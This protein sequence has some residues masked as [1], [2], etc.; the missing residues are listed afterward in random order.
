M[1]IIGF[2]A[3]QNVEFDRAV[4]R[5]VDVKA[6][7]A[8]ARQ[9]NYDLTTAV[10]VLTTGDYDALP[11]SLSD[12]Y[13]EQL[14][15]ADQDVLDVL[16]DMNQA[17]R[18]RLACIESVPRPM[19]DYTIADGRATFTVADSWQ[20]VM[21]YGGDAED[22]N[23]QWYLLDLTFLFRV[24]D[25]RGGQSHFDWYRTSANRKC[26]FRTDSNRTNEGAHHRALQPRARPCRFRHQCSSRASVSLSSSVFSLWS[27]TG[28]H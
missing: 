27:L 19:R 6:M 22:D 1:N 5:V 7:L 28:K 18:W 10:S 20:A 23:T 25:A 13:K 11:T 9:R 4:E 17:I 21:T 24:K 8:Q 15:L 26:S 16:E 12:P 14:R 2:L 3:R